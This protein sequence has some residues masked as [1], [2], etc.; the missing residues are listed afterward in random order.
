M[1]NNLAISVTTWHLA[2]CAY[3]NLGMSMLKSIMNCMSIAYS[4]E[5]HDLQQD[6]HE[7]TYMTFGINMLNN[8]ILLHTK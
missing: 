8:I 5:L 4:Y 6:D 3:C 7:Y 2:L 1:N